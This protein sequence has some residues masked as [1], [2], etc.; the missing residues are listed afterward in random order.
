MN[1]AIIGCGYVGTAVARHFSQLGNVVTATTTTPDRLQELETFA[2]RVFAVKGNNASTLKSVVENQ[3]TVLLSVGATKGNPYEEVYLETA[4]T[5]VSVLSE[6][7]TVQQVIYTA[8]CAIYGERNGA[9]VDEDSIVA[10]T[11]EK[12]EI[13]SKTEQMLL[14]AS[15]ENLR[16]CI[17]RLGGIYGPGREIIKI[18]SRVSGMTRPGDGSAIANWVHLEDIVGAIAFANER[19]LQGIY[20]VV[21]DEKIT[22]KQMLDNLFAKHNLP[23]VIWDASVQNTGSYN[24]RVSNKKIK[25]AGYQLIHPQRLL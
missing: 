18:F 14:S 3:D 25:A 22:R 21:D 23:N 5:L 12:G 20:N 4:N 10:P 6:N 1:I 19:Q 15:R 13:L 7:S 2:R 11:S 8:S 9:W 17:L 16:V 24:A